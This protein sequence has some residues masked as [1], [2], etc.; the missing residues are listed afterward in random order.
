MTLMSVCPS[1]STFFGLGSN[2]RPVLHDQIF[3]LIYFGK[4]GFTHSDVYD[5]PVWLR[6]FYIRKINEVHEERNKQ[7]EKA[8]RKQSN[9]KSVSR[10]GITPRK[11]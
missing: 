8:Q 6:A 3:S 7:Q 2:Y 11:S 5:M 9:K 10:P 4:G 1:G